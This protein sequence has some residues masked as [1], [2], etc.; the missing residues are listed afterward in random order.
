MDASRSEEWNQ[1]SLSSWHSEIGIPKNIQELSGIIN[2]WSCELRVHLEVSMDVRSV[3]EKRWRPRPFCWIFPGISVILSSCD[4]N[5]EQTLSLCREI[6][7]S[8]ESGHLGV[9]FAWSIKHRFCLT[10]IFLREYHSW[11]ACGKLAYLFSRRQ[12][13]SSHL[14][15]I[16]GA[17][18]FHPVAFLKLMFLYTWD[19]CLRESLDVATT[20]FNSAFVQAKQRWW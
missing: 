8:F 7:P 10:Y 18:I 15:K 17:R 19:G 14:Q 5:D 3:F 6:W 13:I 2:M 12:G 11:G 16:C 4:K 9:H 20:W 1:G